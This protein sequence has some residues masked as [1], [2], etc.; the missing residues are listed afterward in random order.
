MPLALGGRACSRNAFVMTHLALIASGIGLLCLPIW[1]L[2]PKGAR[3]AGFDQRSWPRGL[4]LFLTI[5]DAARASVGAWLLLR[6]LPD[7]AQSGALG[8]WQTPVLMAAAV[9]VGLLIQ[10]MAW[11]DEDFVFAPIGYALGVV[12]AVAHP[13]V[14]AITLPLA[15][16]SSLAVRAWAAGLAGLGVGLAAVGLAVTG[17]EWRISLLCGVAFCFPVL[18]SVMVGRHLGSPRK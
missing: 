13:I 17:Q 2:R 10:T 7:L 3:L 4:A 5:I 9:A 8:R 18:V 16:G 15:I 11:R 14:L 12:A 6:G 1:L